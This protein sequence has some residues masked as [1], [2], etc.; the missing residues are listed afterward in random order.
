MMFCENN[1]I[2][3]VELRLTCP[4]C[5][6]Q[7]DAYIGEELVGYLRMRHGCFYVECP[8][9]GGECVYETEP[10]GDGLFEDHEREKYLT[11]AVQAIK[12]WKVRN[13]AAI[14]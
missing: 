14:H 2:D 10:D 1:T 4:G 9:V 11:F 6:E 13:A 8:H 3:G 12:E 5:P 7:Y